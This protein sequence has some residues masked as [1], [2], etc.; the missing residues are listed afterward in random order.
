MAWQALQ[1][2]A[3]IREIPIR[4]RDRLEGQSKLGW[5]TI[6]EA[7]REVPRMYFRKPASR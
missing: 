2:G 1:L 5:P 6:V 7:I 4:F 3:T